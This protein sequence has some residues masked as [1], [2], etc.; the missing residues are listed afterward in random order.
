MG[1]KETLAFWKTIKHFQ[2]EEFDSPDRPGSGLTLMDPSFIRLLD[3]LRESVGFPL[4]ISSGY[5]TPGYNLSLKAEGLKS[6]DGSA[7]TIGKAADI[8]VRFSE[9][10]FK[11]LKTALALSVRRIGIAQ[12]FIHLDTD[13]TK[14]QEVA[15]LY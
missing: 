3:K 15:W 4:V 11:L 9:H 8:V 5:R 6:V 1:K 7:H 13:G 14:P 10:R 2:P 12:T